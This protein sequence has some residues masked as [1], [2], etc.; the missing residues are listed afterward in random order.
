MKSRSLE[1]EGLRAWD[2]DGAVR[3]HAAEHLD[4]GATAALLLE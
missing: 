2:G 1:A 4:D 3:L